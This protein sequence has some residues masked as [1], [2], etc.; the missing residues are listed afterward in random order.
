MLH[1]RK[2]VQLEDHLYRRFIECLLLAGETDED[3]Y[4]PPVADISFTL[5]ITEEELET[6][7]NELVRLGFLEVKETRYYVHNFAKRQAPMDKAE[8]MRRKRDQN[9]IDSYYDV[10]NGNTDKNRIDKIK[11]EEAESIPYTST[12]STFD[13]ITA[14][15]NWG[16][17]RYQ[18]IEQLYVLC[19]NQISIPSNIRDKVLKDL[20]DVLD[21]YGSIERAVPHGQK[22]YQ[23]YISKDK[24]D[25]SGK[26]STL[27]PGWIDKWLDVIY[28]DRANQQVTGA[29]NKLAKEKRV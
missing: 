25:N 23:I 8:Y 12:T 20:G 22:N 15:T 21:Y 13:T 18:D 16:D 10:T 5:R 27:S 1:D 26:Y 6:D 9:K 14:K 4:L 11:E 28:R 3:G 19:T 17:T 24:R 7:L 2:I 29:I